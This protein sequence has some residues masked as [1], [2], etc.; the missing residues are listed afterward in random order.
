MRTVEEEW[1]E[2]KL[3]ITKNEGNI[4][5]IKDTLFIMFHNILPPQEKS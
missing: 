2:Y 4:S 1:S 3:F 5:I